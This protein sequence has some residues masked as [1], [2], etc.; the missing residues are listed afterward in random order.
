MVWSI[1][2]SP[3]TI[4]NRK[5]L[6]NRARGG[7]ITRYHE[8]DLVLVKKMSQKPGV[9][10]SLRPKWEGPFKVIE[11]TSRK[12]VKINFTGR[13]GTDLVSVERIKPY[14]Q[15]AR[16]SDQ[17]GYHLLENESEE[18]S[19]SSEG[20]EEMKENEIDRRRASETPHLNQSYDENR[21]GNDETHQGLIYHPF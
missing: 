16:D 18:D 21:A 11:M 12:T 4:R 3:S 5:Q 2:R 17:L 14:K 8:G 9:G 19:G 1:N 13:R 20:E 6:Q 15:D 7:T 10:R